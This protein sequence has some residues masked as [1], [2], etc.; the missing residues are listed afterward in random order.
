MALDIESEDVTFGF[1]VILAIYAM[2]MS[3]HSVRLQAHWKPVIVL[4]WSLLLEIVHLQTVMYK[5]SPQNL[6][7]SFYHFQCSTLLCAPQ[8]KIDL[9]KQGSTLV[10]RLKTTGSTPRYMRVLRTVGPVSV[11]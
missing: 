6:M 10:Y 1:S 5:H 2:E 11:L 3:L 8:G 4:R 7:Y 9:L